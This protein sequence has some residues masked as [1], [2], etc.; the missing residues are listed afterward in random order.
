MTQSRF[1]SACHQ[2][3][4]SAEHD[5]MVYDTYGEWERSSY[6]SAPSD[7]R[8]GF[9]RPEVVT[10]CQ[11]C[12]MKGYGGEVAK[13]GPHRTEA[14]E[15]L[16][17]GAQSEGM[18]GSGLT[19]HMT[20][21]KSPDRRTLYVTI[22]THNKLAGHALPTGF[23][24]RRLVIDLT[25]IDRE[26]SHMFHERRAYGRIF[27]DA[28]GNSPVPFWIA[29]GVER[30]N[31]INPGEIRSEHFTFSLTGDLAEVR[32]QLLFYHVGEDLQKAY[33]AKVE[34]MVVEERSQ[35]FAR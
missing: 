21:R 16:F 12:H 6:N 19:F 23:P 27:N 14:R 13:G 4:L 9:G 35:K 3:N 20:A 25:G 24:D 15:H 22:Q 7:V 2:G 34:P 31:R 10:R 32:V 28:K 8:S 17:P 18:V 29:T 26:L 11:D 33:R 30:D 5:F 1:C